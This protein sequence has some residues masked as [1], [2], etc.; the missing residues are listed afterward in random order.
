LEQYEGSLVRRTI[1]V[2]SE[3]YQR[4]LEPTE[5]RGEFAWCGGPTHVCNP[6]AGAGL[7]ERLYQPVARL[8][9]EPEACKFANRDLLQRGN[10]ESLR[11][12]GRK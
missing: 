8:L 4:A 2:G 10:P 6:C 1:A 7:E 9:V 12:R 5:Q 3:E 11:D